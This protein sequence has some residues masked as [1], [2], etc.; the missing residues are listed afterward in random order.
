MSL[1]KT[2]AFYLA[3]ML[4]TNCKIIVK[5]IYNSNSSSNLCMLAELRAC[6]L[7]FEFRIFCLVDCRL[8]LFVLK[9]KNNDVNCTSLVLVLFLKNFETT[10]TSKWLFKVCIGQWILCIN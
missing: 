6:F 5:R 2:L 8:P 4:G 3:F 1:F 7:Q 9:R 10:V